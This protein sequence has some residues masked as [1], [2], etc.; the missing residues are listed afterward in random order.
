MGLDGKDRAAAACSS[1]AGAGGAARRLVA[2]LEAQKGA[3]RCE[4]RAEGRKGKS[5]SSLSSRAVDGAVKRGGRTRASG[6]PRPVR[7]GGAV[8]G[9]QA[10]EV[11]EEVEAGWRRVG[12][13]C[14]RVLC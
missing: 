9:R 12:L 1:W 5:P 11:A 8:D 3:V 6:A 10:E 2:V 4:K 14:A 7:R 13:G